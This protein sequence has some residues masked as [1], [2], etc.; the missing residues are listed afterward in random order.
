[1]NE[2]IDRRNFLQRSSA[3]ALG[4]VLAGSGFSAATSSA[5]AAAAGG[6]LLK[7]A[8]IG[9]LPRDIAVMEI[10]PKSRN[11]GNFDTYKKR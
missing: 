1:M 5:S 10:V 6:G 11:S 3:L 7:G 2:R 8:C 4:G 9:V